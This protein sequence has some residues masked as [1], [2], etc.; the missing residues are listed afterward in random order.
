MHAYIHMDASYTFLILRS[1]QTDGNPQLVNGTIHGVGVST[2]L[3]PSVS[4][5][6]YI[7]EYRACIWTSLGKFRYERYESYPHP[8]DCISVMNLFYFHKYKV[9]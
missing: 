3:I 5:V 7:D 4:R 6:T 9:I 8:T 1:D 2:I